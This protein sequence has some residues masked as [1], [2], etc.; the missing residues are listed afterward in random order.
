MVHVNYKLMRMLS[1][2]GIVKG[3]PKL[4]E[5]KSEVRKA[6]QM[7]KKIKKTF[8]GLIEISSTRPLELIHMDLIGPAP[9]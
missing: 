9:I 1:K 4:S 3:I 7:D 5:M 6:C 8:K 2:T